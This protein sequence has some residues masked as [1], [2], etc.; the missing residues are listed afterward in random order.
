MVLLWD[1]GVV[2]LPSVNKL[3]PRSLCSVPLSEGSDLVRL[4]AEVR[5]LLSFIF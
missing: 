3:E 5:T 4:L 1:R 2:D